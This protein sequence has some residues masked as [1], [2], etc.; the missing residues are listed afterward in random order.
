MTN[1]YPGFIRVPE[2]LNRIIHQSDPDAI[3]LQPDHARMVERLRARVIEVRDSALRLTAEELRELVQAAAAEQ[4]LRQALEAARARLHAALLNGEL[5][6]ALLET[7]GRLLAI[8]L[9]DPWR[10]EAGAEALTTGNIVG[11]RFDPPRVHHAIRFNG[12]VLFE[13]CHFERWRSPDDPAT[14]NIKLAPGPAP[15]SLWDILNAISAFPMPCR[16]MSSS[17]E[18]GVPKGRSHSL[19]DEGRLTDWLADKMRANPNAPYPKDAMFQQAAAEGLKMLSGRA[20]ER[21]WGNAVKASGAKAWSKAG[22]KPK[23]AAL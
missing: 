20:N 21:A 4:R 8:D 2:A 23:I 19:A 18:R 11:M 3:I 7:D 9:V 15:K 14:A 6:A 5:Y 22:R 12:S 10:T 17:T 13:E 1:R 16:E